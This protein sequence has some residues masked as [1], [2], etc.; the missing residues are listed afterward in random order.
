MLNNE[1][2]ILNHMSFAEKIAKSQFRKTP[3]QV[4]L[5]ELI[6][7]AYMGLVDASKRYD[8]K[9]NFEIFARW[10]II[11]EI[12]DYLRSLKWDRNTNKLSSIPEN[13]DFVAE[14][15]PESFDDVLD[16]FAKNRISLVAK[17][18]IRMYY[19]QCLPISQIATKTNLSSAR[20]SQLIKQNIETIRYALSA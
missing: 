6:S 2:F 14:K 13:Y 15:E 5:D 9:S 10:R 1:E 7:A 19:G 4:Q 3:P 20:I 8:G 11:G 12:K 18:I 16:D 17:N